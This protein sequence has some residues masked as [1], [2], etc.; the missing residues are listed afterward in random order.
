M[1][2]TK[3]NHQSTQDSSC[4]RT[5]QFLHNRNR[6]LLSNVYPNWRL[7]GALK[8]KDY[9]EIVDELNKGHCGN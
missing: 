8:F 7:P 2:L 4:K 3:K 9:L 1:A 6:T 5:I